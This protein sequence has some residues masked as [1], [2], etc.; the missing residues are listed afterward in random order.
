MDQKLEIEYKK[1]IDFLEIRRRGE[2]GDIPP[3]EIDE[4]LEKNA[5]QYAYWGDK[6]AEMEC[7]LQETQDEYD[8]WLYKKMK[9]S[10]DKLK[11]ESSKSASIT[12]KDCMGKIL[13]SEDDNRQYEQYK[14]NLRFFQKDC[15]MLKS[16]VK[17]YDL[18]G[19]HLMNLAN[20]MKREYNHMDSSRGIEN[21]RIDPMRK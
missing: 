2:L 3:D 21:R 20:R 16:I 14:C 9:I 7:A 5:S 18:R 17:G 11:E 6:L 8:T 15:S 19:F 10:K 4:H 1:A 13:E 12:E